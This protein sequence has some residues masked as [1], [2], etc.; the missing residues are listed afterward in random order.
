[1]CALIFFFL[2]IRRP[3]RS[4]LFPYT[5]LFRS[6]GEAG[7]RFIKDGNTNFIAPD[8]EISGE[9]FSDDMSNFD[10]SGVQNFEKFMDIFIKFVSKDTKL[11]QR[12]EDSLRDEISE[13]PTRIRSEERRVGKE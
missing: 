5:T 2:M 6:C 10:F 11:Y 8:D 1:M 7:V 13:L 9:Q 4:T 12:A 3:P